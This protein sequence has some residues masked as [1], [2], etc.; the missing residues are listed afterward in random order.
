MLT[1]GASRP[2]GAVVNDGIPAGRRKRA[3][4]VAWGQFEQQPTRSDVG[5][6]SNLAFSNRTNFVRV[7]QGADTG[8][9]WIYV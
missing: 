7:Y 3:T 5:E 8:A 9:M 6:K 4:S 2:T 1:M